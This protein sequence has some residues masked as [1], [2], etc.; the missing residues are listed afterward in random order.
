MENAKSFKELYDDVW[1]P[2]RKASEDAKAFIERAAK[3]TK[4][5]ETTVRMWLCGKQSP[6]ALAQDAL[7]KEFGTTADALFPKNDETTKGDDD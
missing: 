3:A 5:S 7:A 6:D 4:R 1:G 2:K